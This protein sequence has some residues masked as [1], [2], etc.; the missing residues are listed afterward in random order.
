MAT[1]IEL[2]TENILSNESSVPVEMA[3]PTESTVVAETS[4]TAKPVTPAEHT[5]TTATSQESVPDDMPLIE[6]MSLRV[7]NE[8]ADTQ[9]DVTVSPSKSATTGVTS[10]V[11]LPFPTLFT[12]AITL[13]M[14]F[15]PLNHICALRPK[16]SS[17][18]SKANTTSEDV[19]ISTSR[20]STDLLRSF[21][22]AENPLSPRFNPTYEVVS[23]KTASAFNLPTK[24]NEKHDRFICYLFTHEPLEGGKREY[25]FID[26]SKMLGELLDTP[27]VSYLL[28][29]FVTSS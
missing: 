7:V 16:L 9:T 6:N 14:N 27:N 24:W 20:T 22:D 10:P 18:L 15:I 5:L 2:H 8:S 4:V 21:L 1:E 28:L 25:T 19:T 12:S 26:M 13:L 23:Q 3:V 11:S 17:S 29:P